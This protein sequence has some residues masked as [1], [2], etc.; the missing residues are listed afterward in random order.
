M[1]PNLGPRFWAQFL[2]LTCGAAATADRVLT[3]SFSLSLASP[4]VVFPMAQLIPSTCRLSV[5]SRNKTNDT[6]QR[7]FRLGTLGREPGQRLESHQALPSRLTGTLD[8]V[9]KFVPSEIHRARN[10]ADHSDLM[11]W[12]GTDSWVF[13]RHSKNK[14]WHCEHRDGRRGLTV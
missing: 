7:S 11:S 1:V 2:V 13:L 8:F 5:R 14:A 9:R 12:D 3:S 6:W 4:A 10:I